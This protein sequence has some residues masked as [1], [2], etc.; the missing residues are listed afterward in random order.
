MGF[1]F[2]RL[3]LLADNGRQPTDVRRSLMTGCLFGKD[4]AT[5]NEKLSQRNV[6]F[7]QVRE[8]GVAVGTGD[9]I[10][11][12]LGEWDEAGV[13]RVMLQWLDLDDM[14]GLEALATSVLSQLS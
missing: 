12:Q 1:I 8:R 13:Q 9:Q 10:V 5:V 2:P 7:T 4:T 6:S 11:E 3:L 14:D